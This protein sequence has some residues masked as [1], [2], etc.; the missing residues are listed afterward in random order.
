[1]K[2][3]EEN[4]SNLKEKYEEAIAKVEELQ[5]E[6]ERL[7]I[8]IAYLTQENQEKHVEPEKKSLLARIFRL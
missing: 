5:Q 2:Q 7:N 1:M 3:G 8:E 6:V 4:L